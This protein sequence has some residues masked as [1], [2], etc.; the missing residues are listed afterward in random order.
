M[1]L[2]Q[3]RKKPCVAKAGI[4]GLIVHSFG[5]RSHGAKHALRPGSEWIRGLNV[6]WAKQEDL[7]DLAGLS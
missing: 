6:A 4:A 3:L 7:Q 2:L 1:E 5:H